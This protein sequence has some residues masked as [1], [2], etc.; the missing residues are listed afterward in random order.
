MLGEIFIKNVD[1]TSICFEFNV[2]LMSLTLIQVRL[3]LVKKKWGDAKLR[4]SANWKK[5]GIW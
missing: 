1:F 3:A 4:M 2:L 5:Y